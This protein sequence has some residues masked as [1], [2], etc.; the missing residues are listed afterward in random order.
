[1][2]I[3]KL[4]FTILLSF[5]SLCICSQSLTPSLVQ[6]LN[7]T[8]AIQSTPDSIPLVLPQTQIKF[9][10]LSGVQKIYLKIIND[11]DSIIYSADYV[12]SSAP[13]I[14]SSGL[15]LFAAN[16][17]TI[18]INSDVIRLDTYRYQIITEDSLGVQTAPFIKLQ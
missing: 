6:E 11:T 15:I 16:G 13:V 7:V 10:N 4:L 8:Y 9:S 5:F 12:L 3:N 1:M 18:S 17:N 14:S 2:L